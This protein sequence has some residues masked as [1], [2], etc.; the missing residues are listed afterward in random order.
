MLHP[1]RH[2]LWFVCGII[3]GDVVALILRPTFFAPKLWLIISFLLLIFAI[4]IPIKLNLYTAFVAGVLSILSRTSPLFISE[5]VYSPLYQQTVV[6]SG[7]I[8]KDPTP[9][10]GKINLTVKGVKISD[11]AA[12]G[13]IFVQLNSLKTAE[14]FVIQRSD[15]IKVRGTLS[16]G[17]GT[18]KA[19]I[20]RAEVLEVARGSPGDLFLKFRNFFADKVRQFIPAPESSL[21]IGY[22]LGDKAGVDDKIQ[23]TLKTIGL[24][25]VI[26]ASGAHLST[27][28][29]AARKIF[30]RVSRFAE[31]FFAAIFVLAFIG[32][33]GLSASMLRAALVTFLSLIAWYVGREF[34]PGRLLLIVAA[35][36][37]LY[38]PAYPTDLAWLLSF[39]SFT[40]I[41][42][43]APAITGFLYPANQPPNPLI[44]SIITSVSATMICAPILLYFFGAVSLISI[45]ANIFIM[46]TIAL[47]MGLT[48]VTGL[49][50]PFAPVASVVGQLT[51]LILKY[52]IHIA[53]FFAKKT[54]FLI[55]IPPENPKILLLLIAPVA[56]LAISWYN[57]K[58][59]TRSSAD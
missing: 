57:N 21:A 12:L 41:M 49:T 48:L 27:L 47:A 38:H 54:Q 15:F 29:G 22:L 50:S 1:S 51:D 26:V 17:F 59:S 25:H 7:Q 20:F 44:A 45:F 24:T 32:I 3:L 43:L 31:L 58:T 40:G 13:T 46:P 6:M 30:G 5:S 11:Q 42:V 53:Q 36:T 56:I 52:Q 16:P 35:I 33:T 14:D 19:A 37:I 55:E 9:S 4:K 8:Q 18:F 23:D 2:F 39:G 10:N 28:V 34:V